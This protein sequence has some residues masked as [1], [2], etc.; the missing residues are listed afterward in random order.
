V[1]LHQKLSIAFLAFAFLVA[2][3]GAQTFHAP[4]SPTARPTSDD[5]QSPSTSSILSGTVQDP[6]GAVISHAIVLLRP[7]AKGTPIQTETDSS[8]SF[9]FEKIPVG[10]YTLTVAAP[11]FKDATIPITFKGK[12]LPPLRV[13]LALA[14]QSETVT[15]GGADSS[16][17]VTTDTS[18]NQSA[19][20]FERAALDRVPVFDQDY[21]TT[22]SRFLD[23]NSVSTNGVSLVVNGI[24][25]N[26]PGVTASAIQ[27]VRINQNPYS[28]LFAN[29]GRARL[30]IT[31]KPGTPALH[32][33]VNFLYR[34]AVFDASNAFAVQKP[35]ESRQYYEGSL[36]GPLSYNEK[37]TF[38]LSFERDLD[39]QQAI[40]RA[41][42]LSGTGQ[43]PIRKNVPAPMH[44]FFGEGR[45]FHEL[46]N[47]DLFWIGYSNENMSNK[48]QNVGGTVL[49]E[50]GY[51]SSMVESE[52]NVS[53]RHAFSTLW[54]N[55]LRF[56]VG[57]NN[58]PRTSVNPAPQIIVSGAF[59]G[60]GAQADSR[61]TEYHFDG[62]DIVTYA[63]GKHLLN[64]GVDIPDI[65]RRGADDFSNQLGTYTFASLADRQANTPSTVVIQQGNG[66]LVFLE[67]V[68]SGFIEDS[69]RINPKFSV[70]VGLRYYWQNF[71]HDDPNNFA[72]RFS[73]AFAPSSKSKTVF[74]GGAGLFYD[75]SGPR[76][77]ADLLHFNGVDLLRFIVPNP[78]FP[79]TPAEL[80]AVP[81]SLVTLDSRFHIP[82]RVQYSFAIERQITAK[83]TFSAGYVGSRGISL[84]RSIDANAP[85]PPFTDRPNPVIGQNR[86]LQSDGY[87]KSNGLELTF[88]GSP[89]RFFN[90]QIQ[91]TLSKTYNNTSGGSYFP[92]NSLD[93]S[94]D[95]A[96]SDN[97]RRH[98][99]DL[100]G[101]THFTGLF[102]LGAAL[103]LYSGKPVNV[104]TGADHNG[105]GVVNDRPLGYAR[106]TLH[107]PGLVNLDLNLSHDFPFSTQRGEHKKDV[108]TLTVSLNS[109]NVFNHP[110]YVTYIGVLGSPLFGQP[111]AANPPRRTQL[112]LEFKF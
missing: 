3:N 41:I 87:Q 37:T 77:I 111:V 6:S 19:N 25:A 80:A 12:R 15:V 50:A 2:V 78:S 58:Q 38:L 44:H 33:S 23:D 11:A 46:E 101:S 82:Y 61:R 4:D 110:N 42:G 89:S 54:S 90:G 99:F 47:G 32:G 91:Y 112:N 88:R 95:W 76:P 29:P 108:P 24:E 26:G 79:V 68:I 31:T 92:G 72:P 34:D 17:Q 104:I 16:P 81:A 74:R 86:Q 109:F 48:N 85:L 49:P 64:F 39:D 73:F 9:H 103:S 84:F 45:V 55:Q 52:I 71:F 22:L 35:P 40:V 105:D 27:E 1:V 75:R 107:G 65:S 83:S 62:T 60:G 106:N 56:L 57:Q 30:E 59:T 66:H 43:V 10:S 67:K 5:S 20:A 7:S 69:I 53:Y 70:T 18:Q 94:A 51:N 96:R 102:T 63:H 28:A 97:D 21:I 100:L 98:K 36:T 14:S 8:G 93:P 13:T